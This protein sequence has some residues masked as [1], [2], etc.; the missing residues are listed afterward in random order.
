VLLRLGVIEWMDKTAPL[1]DLLANALTEAEQKLLKLVTDFHFIVYFKCC[2]YSL[3]TD[4]CCHYI[5][6]L[7]MV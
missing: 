3:L 5:Y 1:K 4:S 7:E 2:S 6:L